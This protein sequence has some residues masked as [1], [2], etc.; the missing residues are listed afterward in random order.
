MVGN[1]LRR[2]IFT[3]SK[4]DS[5]RILL[6]AMLTADRRNIFNIIAQALAERGIEHEI[7]AIQLG[8]IALLFDGLI[9]VWM[10]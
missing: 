3:V 4:N 10:S 7:S 2:K 1:P 9:A 8:N 6:L 5:E